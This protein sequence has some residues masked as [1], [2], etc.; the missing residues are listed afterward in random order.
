MRLIVVLTTSRAPMAASSASRVKPSRRA[1]SVMYGAGGCC[2]WSGV[3]RRIA[4]AGLE[5][6][7]LEQQLPGGQRRRQPRAGERLHAGRPAGAYGRLRAR[8]R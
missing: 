4:S 8:R 1:A 5:A 6:L 3:S 2:A 7:A